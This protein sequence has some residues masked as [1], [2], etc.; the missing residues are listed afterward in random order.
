[1]SREGTQN[2]E[3]IW[4]NTTEA[5]EERICRHPQTVP[6]RQLPTWL[7]IWMS[8][9]IFF[10]RKKRLFKSWHFIA[11][12]WIFPDM[13]LILHW[14]H[15]PLAFKFPAYPSSRLLSLPLNLYSPG[16]GDFCHRMFFVMQSRSFPYTLPMAIFSS[17][18]QQQRPA[19]LQ[20]HECLQNW[21]T[22]FSEF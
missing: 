18:A 20:Y 1:M 14:H 22:P 5:R 4:E 17:T 8:M 3:D 12:T 2:K 9:I 7:S 21:L 15:T 6:W 13:K 11:K 16:S 10:K 19:S